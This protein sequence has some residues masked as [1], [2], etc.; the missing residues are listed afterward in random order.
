MTTP[1]SAIPESSCTGITIA[2]TT[3]A[4]AAIPN[5]RSVGSLGNAIVKYSVTP[6]MAAVPTSQV[7]SDHGFQT[8]IQ[9]SNGIATAAVAS[10]VRSTYAF[11]L[12]LLAGAA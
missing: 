12:G 6:T 2:T 4:P 9:T 1:E 3:S 5:R 8:M 7:K 11:A 10:L